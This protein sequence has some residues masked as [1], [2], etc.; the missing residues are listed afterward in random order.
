MQYLAYNHLQ[1]IRSPQSSKLTLSLAIQLDGIDISGA[2]AISANNSERT[3]MNKM[4]NN[5]NTL[6][7]HITILFHTGML[8]ICT[9]QDKDTTPIIWCATFFLALTA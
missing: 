3:P 7:A 6:T 1:K 4:A 5:G 9:G 8:N 2:L